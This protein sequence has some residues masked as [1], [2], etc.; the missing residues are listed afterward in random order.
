MRLCGISFMQLFRADLHLM[1]IGASILIA[2]QPMQ[3]T[4]SG[5]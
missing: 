3:R 2:N 5:G 4:E 1:N